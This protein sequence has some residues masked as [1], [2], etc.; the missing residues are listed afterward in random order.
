MDQILQYRTAI[1]L[2][3][4]VFVSSFFAVGCASL[5]HVD[6][7]E[8]NGKAIDAGIGCIVGE[9]IEFSMD[10]TKTVLAGKTFK[11]KWEKVNRLTDYSKPGFIFKELKKFSL[12]SPHRIPLLTPSLP[13]YNAEPLH[14]KVDRILEKLVTST[15]AF[16]APEHMNI[17]DESDIQLLLGLNVTADSLVKMIE[18]EGVIERGT[19]KISNIMGARLVGGNFLIEAITPEQQLISPREVTEWKWFITPKK[20]GKNSL[21]LTITAIINFNGEEKQRAIRTFEKT[22]LVNVTPRQKIADFVN[23][24]GQWLWA[25]LVAPILAIIW[26]KLKKKRNVQSY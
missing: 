17:E 21:H 4:L 20:E 13:M 7:K 12:Y 19:I 9:K 24:N 15:I 26:K 3:F 10:S 22:I 14:A 5:N 18:E 23:H 16:N 25:V 8:E 6:Q 2:L 1:L 11:V